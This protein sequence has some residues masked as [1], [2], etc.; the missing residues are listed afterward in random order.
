M[1]RAIATSE[2]RRPAKT[3]ASSAGSSRRVPMTLAETATPGAETSCRSALAGTPAPPTRATRSVA[4]AR[5]CASYF[6][7]R[8]LP[9][10][11]RFGQPSQVRITAS[12]R[13]STAWSAA[14]V[15]VG[16][17]VA[18]RTSGPISGGVR[19]VAAGRASSVVFQPAAVM[20]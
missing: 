3:P 20:S 17:S 8:P 7:F 19:G 16:N 5:R 2:A 13:T 6:T 4:T 1:V 12:P 14:D 10:M 9:G 11:P 18:R 15:G